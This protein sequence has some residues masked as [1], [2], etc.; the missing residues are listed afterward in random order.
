MSRFFLKYLFQLCIIFIPCVVFA[1]GRD[2]NFINLSTKEGLSSNVVNTIVKDHLGFMWFGTNDGL[3]R[4]DGQKFIV[5]RHKSDDEKSIPSSEVLDIFEDKTGD[6]WL[7]TGAGLVFYDRKRDSFKQYKETQYMNITAICE[8]QDH[9]IW[10]SHY[11]GI[12]LLN[13]RTQK[14]SQLQ[15]P[16]KKDLQVV[17]KTVTD[18]FVDSK[19]RIWLGTP[20][21]LFLY[22]HQNKTLKQF[23][24]DPK[25]PTSLPSNDVETIADDK[26]GNIWIGTDKG[27]SM[28]MPNETGFINSFHKTDDPNSLSSNIVYTIAAD[29]EGKLWIGTEDGLNILEPLKGKITRIEQKSRNRYSLVGKSVKYIYIDANGSS[30]V[31]TFRGGVNKYDKNL[32]FFNLRESNRF[33]PFGLSAAMVTSFAPANDGNVF[34]GTD[35]GGL[36]LFN[37][38]SDRFSHTAISCA[39]NSSKLSI[40]A[41][42]RREREL[43]IGTYLSGIYVLN[44]ENG[45]CRTY[46]TSSGLSSNNIFCLKVD[47]RGNV[48]IGTNGQGVDCYH[49]ESNSFVN[50]ST[51]KTGPFKLPING[52]IRAFEE[53]QEGNIWIGCNGAGLTIYNP[54]TKTFK[55]ISKANSDLPIDNIMTLSLLKN[56]NMAIGTAGGGMVIFDTETNKM[57][58]ISEKDGLANGMIEKIIEDGNQKLWLSTNKGL[59]SYDQASKKIK[60]YGHNNGIQESPFVSGSGIK[61]A[62]GNVFFGGTDGFNFFNPQLLNSNKGQPKVVLTELKVSYQ[63][64]KPAEDAPI[65]EEI[66]IAQEINIDYK[67]SFSI[68]FMALNYASPEETRYYYKLENFDKDWNSVGESTSAGYTNLD[69]G[70]Y[71]FKVKAM[72]DAGEWTSDERSIKIIV[73]PPF[74]RTYAAYCLYA[75]FIIGILLFIRRRGIQKLKADFLLQQER[76]DVQQLIE[77]ERREAERAQEFNQM[78]IKFLT[79]VSHEFR[80][81]ISL[82]MGPVEQL[83]QQETSAAKNQQL[84]MV[85]RN[86]RR[87]LNLVNQLLDFRNI[88]E[89]EQKLQCSEADFVAFSKDVADSF[90]D[91]AERKGITFSFSSSLAHYFTSFD[92]D[93]I[94]RIFF[95]LLSNAFKF[96]PEGG[97]IRFSI[98]A[99]NTNKQ[100]LVVEIS[101]TGIGMSEQE[102]DKIFD[103]FYQASSHP[104]VLNQGSGIGLSIAKEFVRLHGG[105]IEVE[106]I[107]NKGSV[108]TINFPFQSILDVSLQEEEVLEEIEEP[109][110]METGLSSG[111]STLP[112]ILLVEDNEDF[113]FYLKD[114]L[115]TFYRVTE[116][117]NGKDGWQKVL[118]SHPQL[119]VSDISMPQVSG[120]ELCKKI[121]SDKRT[122]H[123]PVILLTAL[124][125][126]ENQLQGLEI[127]ASDYMTKPFNFEILHVKIRNLLKL[128]EQLKD[129]YSKQ[130][131]VQAPNIAV[132]S[133]NEKLL[134]K[135]LGF[136]E[137]N[138]NNSKLSVEELSR[139]VGM[140]RGSLYSKILQITGET[141]V[142]FIRSVKL[143]KAAALLE[144]S[145]LNVA[146]V[147]YSVGFATPNYFARAFKARFNMLPSEY[148][149]LKRIEK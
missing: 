25:N 39:P 63:T 82:I 93:K 62:N 5:Y 74:W 14:V 32:P 72:S 92:Q 77:Q 94:E 109:E 1:Q 20:F 29:T 73:H 24:H 131:K 64:V 28:L 90:K 116:A 96:T 97:E 38:N 118:A 91:L 56:G 80:T 142:E 66:S 60:N 19:N 103:R 47:S 88:K 9:H 107:A 140:S 149:Q 36:N 55:W 27:L 101:D 58:T 86:A 121:R 68:S 44:T 110:L 102:I 111:D 57:T 105:T 104:T 137:A 113:R 11:G 12:V 26:Q 98:A 95:N 115:K 84:N 22:Q 125:G 17:Q 67:Q 69:P 30:W 75:L 65:Q 119:V 85:R 144:K 10:A 132:E 81:P 106:S 112:V 59:S 143:D 13:R 130:L 21:G 135:T 51:Q 61:L 124:T 76:R 70:T 23:G 42:C 120:I 53:D 46:N 141:P 2:L 43:W 134:A 16:L 54:L 99:S 146:Q 40:L 145:D 15:L 117:S 133:E 123:I 138:L 122:N 50:Y 78:R 71:V 126:E 35:G 127:G 45:A 18:L 79:N 108:F 128:N 87:L 100:G 3:N 33:D 37:P 8:D 7:A 6:L 52:F 114:N 136:I 31:S 49:P 89:Q 48:W 4:Y 83:L 129:T 148:I 147:C 34:I 139:H 41:L